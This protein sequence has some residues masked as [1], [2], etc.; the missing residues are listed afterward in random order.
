LHQ[1]G[2]L[3]SLLVVQNSQTSKFDQEEIYNQFIT[4]N[5]QSVDVLQAS[6]SELE[7]RIIKHESHFLLF[8]VEL[9]DDAFLQLSYIHHKFPL[10]N[11]IYY[12]SQLKNWEF[13]E[14]YKAGINYCIIG[15]ARQIHLIRTLN[16]LWD[17]HWRRIPSH[18]Y[19]NGL[20]PLP[21]RALSILNFIENQPIRYFN[22]IDLALHLSISESRFRSEFKRFFNVSFRDFKQA[23]FSHYETVLLFEKNLKPKEIFGILDYKN[24]SAF[25][26]SFRSRHGESW[27]HTK[28]LKA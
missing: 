24:I 10:L 19:E 1:G 2:N 27:Q 9:N 28:R 15:D 21:K 25:S 18:L 4:W 20:H 13:A 17:K 14:L 11:I 23:L 8:A 16:Q 6:S 26:R 7:Q 22:S 12:Y 3:S 5:I